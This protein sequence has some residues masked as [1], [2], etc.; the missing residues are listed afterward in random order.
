MTNQE[1]LLTQDPETCT[2]MLYWLLDT[3]ARMWTI[4]RTAVTEWLKKEY[5]SEADEYKTY[6][7]YRGGFKYE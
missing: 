3:Y 5:D 2:D 4:S 7:K 1:Y 6:L